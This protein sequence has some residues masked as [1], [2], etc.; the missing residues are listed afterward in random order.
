MNLKELRQKLAG[1][2]KRIAQLLAQKTRSDEEQ[3]E[4]QSLA[5]EVN[6]YLAQEPAL[7]A[8]EAAEKA[9]QDRIAAEAKAKEQ[10]AA[11][12]KKAEDAAKAEEAEKKAKMKKAEEK[13]E[14]DRQSVKQA[15]DAVV[16][17][18]KKVAQSKTGED[19]GKAADAIK[20]AADAIKLQASGVP[21]T[22]GS[23]TAVDE[24]SK[25]ARKAADDKVAAETEKAARVAEAGDGSTP[26]HHTLWDTEDMEVRRLAAQSSIGRFLCERMSGAI[27]DGPEAELRAATKTHG[28][29]MPLCMLADPDT[30]RQ[31]AQNGGR[32]QLSAKSRFGRQYLADAVSAGPIGEVAQVTMPM[33]GLVFADSVTDYLGVVMRE[34]LYNKSIQNVVS[35][36]P[37]VEAVARGTVK[38]ATA[39]TFAQHTLA[40][41]RV[42]VAMLFDNA[43]QILIP[44][45][46]PDL[47]A[48]IR[49]LI[50]QE[51]SDLVLN[52]D[53]APAFGGL[54]A[55]ITAPNEPTATSTTAGILAELQPNDGLYAR[56][57][58][59]VRALVTPS[60]RATLNGTI[61][62]GTSDSV[63]S[64]FERNLGGFRSTALM[65]D[66]VAHSMAA[67]GF[68]HQCILALM[69]AG[70]GPN[71]CLEHWAGG[72]RVI[73]DEITH[74]NTDRIKVTF[75]DYYQAAVYRSKGFQRKAIVVL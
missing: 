66:A 68:V 57:N 65:P 36:G 45:Y 35:T 11:D 60:L 6:D 34:R 62:S 28:G 12:A 48:N 20:K 67:K 15:S 10:E 75:V 30:L 44:N 43:D 22:E 42:H 21:G 59:D 41:L 27:G 14:S 1:A 19:A 37:T 51:V 63:S 18:S 74:E 58:A 46:E 4:L 24:A 33:I 23:V 3:T 38:E 64:F 29:H 17:D 31:S 70:N 32:V 73:Y 26:A 69:G 7:M 16:A 47:R 53:T 5:G 52:G 61:L 55:S 9:E 72:M 49:G 13:A 25:V 71:A 56:S 50:M 39:F 2:R 54:L 8:E 40:P